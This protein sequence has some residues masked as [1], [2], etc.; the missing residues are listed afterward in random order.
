M[1]RGTCGSQ[2]GRLSSRPR[3]RLLGWN[4]RLITNFT[5]YMRS[6]TWKLFSALV[7]SLEFLWS[8]IRCSQYSY[9]NKKKENVEI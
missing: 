9:V 7:E 6:G 5:K 8:S 4:G 1:S 2:R 3:E